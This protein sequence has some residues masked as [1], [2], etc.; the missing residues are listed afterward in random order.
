[1]PLPVILPVVSTSAAVPCGTCPSCGGTLYAGLT[2]G[3][4]TQVANGILPASA[5]P[6]C[7][8]SEG[9]DHVRS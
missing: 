1:V 3:C 6:I 2:H 9:E 4:T 8:V 5:I 7:P